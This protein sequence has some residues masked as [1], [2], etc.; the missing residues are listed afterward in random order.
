MQID[1]NAPR[2]ERTISDIKVLVPQP[3]AAGQP[4][5]EATAAILNQTL[6]E[7]VSNNLR[8]KLALGHVATEGG[9]AQPHTSESAQKVVDT[10]LEAYEPGVKRGGGGGAPRV[11][12]PVEKEARAI[13]K[14][15]ATEIVKARGLKP[16]DVNMGE[17]TDKL[18]E[19]NKDQLMKAAKRIV[20]ARTKTQADSGLSLDG[21]DFGAAGEAPAEEQPAA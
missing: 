17:I 9:E 16:A 7:N 12:D 11:T 2:A 19:G 18:F 1:P 20:D 21:I 14:A 4:L 15:K 13:A 8:A 6:A 3:Y 5:T 10:Y